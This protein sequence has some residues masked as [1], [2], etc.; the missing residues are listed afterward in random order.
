MF[1]ALAANTTLLAD[2]GKIEI[3]E[4]IS[5]EVITGARPAAPREAAQMRA[6]ERSHPRIVAVMHNIESAIK[7]LD[8]TPDDFGGHKAEARQNLVNSLISLKKA[9]YYRLY[10]DTH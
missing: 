4:K 3:R 1:V 10:E 7:I 6:E 5:I 8:T 9:L 2:D